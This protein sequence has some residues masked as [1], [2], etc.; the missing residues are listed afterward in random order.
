MIKYMLENNFSANFQKWFPHQSIN[1]VYD[2]KSIGFEGEDGLVVLLIPD[3]FQ[4]EKCSDVNLRLSW[5]NVFSYM[6]TDESYRPE[7]WATEKNSPQE[8][9]SFYTSESSDYLNK[10][11]DRNYLIPEKT[12]HFFICGTNLMADIISDEFPTVSFQKK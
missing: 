9:W 12:Y 1:E 2:V 11:R 7:M 6:V 3:N 10:L 4:E 8:A 5:S